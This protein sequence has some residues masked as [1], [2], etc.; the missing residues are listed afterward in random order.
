MECPTLV[1]GS[2]QIQVNC[3]ILVLDDRRVIVREV[4]E[5]GRRGLPL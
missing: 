3:L 5:N 2:G 1:I 4:L